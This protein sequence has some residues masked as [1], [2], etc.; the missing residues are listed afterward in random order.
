MKNLKIAFFKASL[1]LFFAILLFASCDNHQEDV[2]LFDETELAEEP[3]VLGS[4]AINPSFKDV[5]KIS[6]KQ[7]A[8]E[9]E[10]LLENA[11]VTIRTRDSDIDTVIL[12]DVPYSDLTW[13]IRISPNS[14]NILLRS[15]DYV[16][17]A[18]FNLNE[19]EN[20]IVDLAFFLDGLFYAVN[21]SEEVVAEYPDIRAEITISGN[22]AGPFVYLPNSLINKYYYQLFPFEGAYWR[23]IYPS[24]TAELTITATENSG[25][26]ITLTQPLTGKTGLGLN[27]DVT[28][29]IAFNAQADET[30]LDTNITITEA[31][32]ITETVSFPPTSD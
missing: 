11:T 16:A 7:P 2:I 4:I 22:S 13:P 30:S 8:T 15:G 21:F 28:F 19:G 12:D 29:N 14:Y 17:E 9:I 31:E 27:K 24:Q 25:E 26:V 1:K 23:F 10:T 6:A 18:F 3:I 5:I 20:E 32:E